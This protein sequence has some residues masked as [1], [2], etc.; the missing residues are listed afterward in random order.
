[1]IIMPYCLYLRKS[2]ADI[3]AESKGEEETLARHEKALLE[4]AKR[5][6]FN[7]THIY[8]EVVS[9]ET[10]AARPIMQQLLTEVEQ[11]IWEG[12]LVMEVE[13]LARGDTMD[14]GL[15]AQTFKYS[16][17]KI[18]TPMKTYDPNNEYDEEYFEFGLFMS[19]REYKTINRRL[20]RGRIASVKEGK[21]LGNK[22]PYGY[23]RKKLENQKGYTLEIVPEQ[24]EIV[25][26]VYELYTTGELQANGSTQRLG[27][28]LIVRKLNDLRIPPLNSDA[29]V[30][31]TIQGMLR[32]PVYIGKIR[33]NARPA[34]KKMVDGEMK[35]ERPRAD[36][37]DWILVEGLHAAIIDEAIFNLAQ[38]YMSNNKPLPAPK[39]RQIKNPLAGLII[40][41]MCGRR[42]V[43]RP[44]ARNYP[45]GLMCPVTS[46]SNVSSQ[47]QIVEKRLLEALEQW[48][49]EYKMNWNISE[50]NKPKQNIQVEINK[51]AVKKLD[52][53][54][55]NLE[56]QIDNI[57]DL[58][59][60]GV[61]STDTFLERSKVINEKINTARK[62]KEDMLKDLHWQ[63]S[64][65]EN[66]QVFIPK[67]ERA[68]ELYKET[69][70]IALKNELLKGII[71]KAVYTKTQG[72]RWHGTLDDFELSLLPKVPK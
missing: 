49:Q 24:A 65:E 53:E 32:N 23:I 27:V 58:L 66:L 38:E 21:Y 70:D 1:M 45:D 72:S 39:D 50:E 10:I 44:Y 71:E 43:R 3:E 35:R 52:D 48:L 67:V 12:V 4:L 31:S 14:Q 11:G 19:R 15:V 37:V 60:Q 28:S 6:K 18:I 17:T 2:R 25:K 33:W 69:D 57:H 42:M 5:Q 68:M 51:K 64:R 36:A 8:R 61:Y 30:M 20:Q 40:C 22:P 9:G 29:W 55:K 7:I 56:K 34:V 26:L 16:N 63:I 13:R 46:C 47:L 62:G 59:E 54:I 41:G